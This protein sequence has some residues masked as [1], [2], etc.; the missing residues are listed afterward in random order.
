MGEAHFTQR[1]YFP[2]YISEEYCEFL[3]IENTVDFIPISDDIPEMFL[4]WKKESHIPCSIC[5]RDGGCVDENGISGISC[6][7]KN[8]KQYYG[9]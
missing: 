4:W 3:P 9:F 1:L 7:F 2:Y 8:K 6:I 5:G